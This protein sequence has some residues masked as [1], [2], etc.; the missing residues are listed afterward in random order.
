M[1]SIPRIT[2]AQSM[3]ALSSQATVA[4]YKAALLAADRLPP[5]LPDADDR[6]RH[7]RAG[8]GARAR[9][10]RR[11]PA[12]DRDRAAARRGRHRL[13]RP[14]GRAR[15]DREPRRERSST[16]ASS[17]RRPRAATRG[18]LTPEEQ[19]RSSRRSSRRGSPEFDVVITTAAIPGRPAPRLIPASAVAAMRPGSVIV[20]LAAETGGN[21]ELTEPG[22][23][24]VR[25]GVTI[26][27]LDE[28]AE[29]DAVPR[30]PALRA[31][32]L[33]AAARTSRP[34]ASSRSTGTT[35]SPPA[36]A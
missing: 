3:D 31:Q 6:R 23:E 35:R 15:A 24:V 11:R 26:V 5:L 34:R 22:E 19:Q 17:A 1:E 8:E 12:G 28:P 36:P 13:R 18:E 2:R 33:R 32:R 14:A 25:E 4:G 29:H 20:D 9:R 7:G 16:S 21:C 30:E 10:R 27:G